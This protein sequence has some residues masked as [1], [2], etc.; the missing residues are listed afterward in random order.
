MLTELAV[1]YG[2]VKIGDGSYFCPIRS[3][4]VMRGMHAS[5]TASQNTI[6]LSIN[7]VAF[8]NYHRFGTTLRVLPADSPQ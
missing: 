1:Q 2:K 5:K 8:S 7:E 6:L 4:A 3:V